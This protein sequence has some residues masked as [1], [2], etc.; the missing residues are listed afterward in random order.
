MSDSANGVDSRAIERLTDRLERFNAGESDVEFATAQDGPLADLCAAVGDLVDDVRSHEHRSEASER[1]RRELYRI[2]SDAAASSDEKIERLLDL[3]R[4]Y[5]GVENGVLTQIDP[6]TDR[7]EVELAAGG[8]F[9]Q[10]GTSPLSETFCRKTITSGDILGIY[11]AASEGFDA[12]PGYS[13]WGIAC[14]IGGRLEVDDELYG[15]LC[16]VDPDPRDEPFT[17]RDFVFADLLT[18]WVSYELERRKLEDYRD[19]TV[20]IIDTLDD[21]FYILDE[22][23]EALRWNETFNETVGYTDEQI[24]SM[25]PLEFF[26]PADHPRVVEAIERVFEDGSARIDAPFLTAD[27]ES[28]PHEFVASRLESPE[29]DPVLVGIGR[30]ISER[31]RYER[32]LERTRDLLT[33]SQRLANVG[34][35]ELEAAGD[36]VDVVWTDEVARIHGWSGTD[37]TLEQMLAQYRPADRERIETAID[38]AIETGADYDFEARLT[39][40]DGERRWVRMIA[41]SVT[42]DGPVTTLR[43][44]IQDVTERK[45]HERDLE[46]TTDL[47]Q[48]VQRLA[49]VGGWEVDFR[50]DPPAMTWTDELYRIH[51]FDRDA[52]LQRESVVEAYHPA[53]RE[54]VD[55]TLREAVETETAYDIEARLQTDAGIRWVRAIGEPI[56]EDGDL[57]AFRGSVQDISD[58]K[59]REQDLQRT[60]ALL[61]QTQRIANVGGWELDLTT[62]PPYEGTLTDELYR[63]HG[64]PLEEPFDVERGLEFY[65]PDDRDRVRTAVETAIAAREPYDIEARLLTAS[66]EQRWV[67]TTGVPI[68]DAEGELVTLRGALQDITERKERELA[69]R[70]L[71]ET[72]HSLLNT[73]TEQAVAD[74]IVETADDALEVTG[75]CIYLLD[76]TSN[77]LEPVA[78]SPQVADDLQPIAVGDADSVVWN[79]FATGSQTVVGSSPLLVDGDSSGLV[80]PMGVH[81]VFVATAPAPDVDDETRRLVETLVATAEAAFDRLESESSLRERDAELAAQNRR[82]KRQIQVTEIIRAIDQSLVGSTS[83]HEIERTVCERLVEEPSIDFAWIGATDAGQEGLAPRTWAGAEGAYLDAV[84]FETLDTSSEPAVQTARTEDSTV[85]SN[86]VG[87]LPGDPWRTAALASGFHSVCSVPLAFDEYVYGVLSVYASEPDAFGDLERTVFEELGESI[88]NAINAVTARQALHT[89]TALELTVTITDSGTFLERLA[90]A[91]DC[92]LSFEGL[93]AHAADETRLFFTADGPPETVEAV[94]DEFVSVSSFQRISESGEETLFEATV[95]GDV[96]ASRLVRH[97]ATPRSIVATPAGVET[98]VDLSTATDVREFLEMLDERY[99]TVELIRRRTVSRRTHTRGHLI[100]SLFDALTD[101]QLEVLKTAYF[102]GYFDWPRE[103]TGEEVAA[104]LGVSQPAVNRHLRVGNRRLLEQLFDVDAPLVAGE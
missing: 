47:L 7:Y 22:G 55:A 67:Q 20:E 24:D 37:A 51:C 52:D 50:R 57:V 78:A 89:D 34:A 53:D 84:S 88:A 19:Y 32:E 74:L 49:T 73:E 36:A 81:G 86:V 75:A 45:R 10:L 92:R 90:R 63:I 101:R 46:R 27:G 14:Y 33:Q 85:V 69:I 25:S 76:A 71:H 79:V 54:R 17:R 72:T 18:R 40:P 61:E 59:E 83:R 95:S 39:R 43:G 64:V 26:P 80:V 98:V 103:S 42:D 102:A 70:S 38:R 16:F 99:P 5:F 97:G 4:R 41:T 104:M 66:G 100:D 3:G 65:H 68:T 44:S 13:E 48:Q 21:V 62:D 29:G 30:D 58:R 1:Y 9:V 6:D 28:I 82:L 23:G 87:D 60:T 12:D 93:P 15:T 91:A 35:W 94:L 56:H 96:L 2:T 11:D 8:T 77:R 31:A